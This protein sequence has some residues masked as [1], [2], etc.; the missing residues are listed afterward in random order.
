M[1]EQLKPC[2]F[3]NSDATVFEITEPRLYRPSRN[4]PYCVCC[5]NCDLF[6]GHDVDYDGTFDTKEEASE[7]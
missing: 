4:R 1:T 2:P 5:G 3:C 7:A 6:F